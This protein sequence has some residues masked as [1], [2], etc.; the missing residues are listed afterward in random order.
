MPSPTL[1]AVSTA[2]AFYEALAAGDTEEQMR[3]LALDARYF[4][5][6]YGDL[7]IRHTR[8]AWRLW[9]MLAVD[10]RV[11]W[12]RLP[13]GDTQTARI[14][15]RVSHTMA[16]SGER[17][18]FDGVSDVHVVDGLILYLHSEYDSVVWLPHGRWRRLVGWLP[19]IRLRLRRR[20]RADLEQWLLRFPAAGMPPKPVAGASGDLP[21]PL[22]GHAN[23]KS[24]SP[25]ARDEDTTPLPD[26]PRRPAAS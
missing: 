12:H 21:Y 14:A 10:R 15:W 5:P 22:L 23:Q 24:L 6:L 2:C 9:A 11:D 7:D 3:W 20:A 8:A 26:P 25:R 17:L 16:Q 18:G 4:D 19:L 1:E 13:G